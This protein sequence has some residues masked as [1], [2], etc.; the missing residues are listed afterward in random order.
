V[1]RGAALLTVLI[2]L[3]GACGSDRG[4]APPVVDRPVAGQSEAQNLTLE[5]AGFLAAG[6]LVDIYGVAADPV[7]TSVG[8]EIVEF[9][10]QAVWRLDLTVEVAEDDQRVSREWRMWVGTPTDGPPA[11]IRAQERN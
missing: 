1:S 2:V 4:F 6:Q 8:S 11:V 3:A 5:E 10:D 9:D 7:P